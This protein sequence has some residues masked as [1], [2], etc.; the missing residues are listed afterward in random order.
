MAAAENRSA[1]VPII[2]GG[3]LIVYSMWWLY[4]DHPAHDL[5]T[6]FRRAFI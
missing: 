1:L 3:L 6:G 2:V 4:F 5:L